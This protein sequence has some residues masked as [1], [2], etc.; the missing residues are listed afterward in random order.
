M[1]LPHRWTK[2]LC[3]IAIM[4][5]IAVGCSGANEKIKSDVN[6]GGNSNSEKKTL[7]VDL[8]F[9]DRDGYLVVEK[10]EVPNNDQLLETVV[11]E[12]VSGPA[13]PNLMETIPEGVEVRSVRLS[14]GVAIADFSREIETNH[15]GGSLGESITV[16]SI[17]NTLCQFDDVESVEINVEGQPIETLAGHLDLSRPLKANQN[18]VR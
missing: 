12:L 6:G 11:R 17:V 5:L 13:D 3:F 15:W 8:Y 4:G 9:S 18:L 1:G 16:Y 10:R 7:V 14:N 2:L